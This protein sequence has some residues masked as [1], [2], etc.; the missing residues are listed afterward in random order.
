MAK[1]DPL[2]QWLCANSQWKFVF[3]F[4]Q[5]EKILGF[6]LPNAARKNPAWWSNENRA[7][8][9]HTQCKAWID[10]GFHVENLSLKDETVDFVPDLS[11]K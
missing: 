10:A 8:T 1:Y 5:I 3:T 6:T 2:Y 11:E 4:E 7:T 9:H